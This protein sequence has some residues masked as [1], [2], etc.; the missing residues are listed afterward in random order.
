MGILLIID[1]SPA[2]L[3][4]GDHGGRYSRAIRYPFGTFLFHAHPP[5]G[6]GWIIGV[7]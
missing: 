7:G 2:A 1:N 4:E 6:S 5:R 3:G